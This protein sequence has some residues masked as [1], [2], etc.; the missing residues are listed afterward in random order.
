M[1]K[2]TFVG[3]HVSPEH[4]M[5]YTFHN[6]KQNKDVYMVALREGTKLIGYY[7]KHE[8]KGHFR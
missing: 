7:E 3:F 5:V 4:N 2:L 8:Y 6:A 1:K